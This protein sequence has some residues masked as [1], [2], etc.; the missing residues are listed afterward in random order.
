MQAAARCE[1]IGRLVDLCEEAQSLAK[2]LDLDFVAFL[3]HMVVLEARQAH[4]FSEDDAQDDAQERAPLD[5]A[6]VGSLRAT[7]KPPSTGPASN[8]TRLS[9]YRDAAHA[10]LAVPAQLA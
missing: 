9:E 6:P 2:A 5:A 3:A 1:Q 4:Y 8:V 10:R 7:V